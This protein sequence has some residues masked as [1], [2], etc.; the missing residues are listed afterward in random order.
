[1][2]H[3]TLR[4]EHVDNELNVT[5]SEQS[6]G[7]DEVMSKQHKTPNIIA[8]TADILLSK[9]VRSLKEDGIIPPPSNV[10]RVDFQRRCLK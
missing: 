8:A 2:S 9:I 10:L 5:R 4:L 7:Y 6:L 1:M 3:F